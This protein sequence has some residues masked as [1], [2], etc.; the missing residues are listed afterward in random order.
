[1]KKTAILYIRVSTDEQAE[2]G[3]S[4][5]EQKDRLIKHCQHNG[6]E[7]AALYQEDHSAKSFERPEWK[8]LQ[9]FAK[10]NKGKIDLI[11]VVDWSRFSRNVADAFMMIELLKK[12]KIEVQAID[13]PLDFAIPESLIMLS[14]Y[15]STPQVENMRR[16][17]RVKAGMR[18]AKIEGRVMSRAPIGYRNYRDEQGRAHITPTQHCQLMKEAFHDIEKG[19]YTQLEIRIRLR[20][21]GLKLTRSNFSLL[22]RNPVYCGYIY[23]QEEDGEQR[24]IKAQHEPIIDRE[25]FLRVQDILDGN[26]KSPKKCSTINEIL[27]L[28]GFLKCARCNGN[29]TGSASKGR[30]G[31]KFY[32]YHCRCGCPERHRASDINDAVV[33]FLEEIQ[34]NS[35]VLD[36][37]YK[38][39]KDIFRDNQ[40]E[41][42][43]AVRKIDSDI[44]KNQERINQAQTLMLDGNLDSTE[45]RAIN[46]RYSEIILRLKMER[47]KLDNVD[48]DFI[49]YMEYDMLLLKNIANTYKGVPSEL[50]RKIIG[51]IFTEKIIFEN[52]ECRTTKLNQVVSLILQSTNKFHKNKKGLTSQNANQSCK[53]EDNGVEPMTSCMP[54]KRSSQLS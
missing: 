16:S 25:L 29:L 49:K 13:Q 52:N 19:I 35:N 47:S 50:K 22:L 45:Y 31:E 18:R 32:Y 54:C 11:Y 4:L 24:L 10:K 8:K 43:S 5:L 38:V 36:L 15:L 27:P 12:L 44:A 21:K 30:S 51:S 17:I 3:Y 39:M 41:N 40:K 14:V 34:S 26:K 53:V 46:E 48:A 23:L 1:M 7:I 33:K 37:Y 42:D 6:I 28:R 9:D 2:K 20:R